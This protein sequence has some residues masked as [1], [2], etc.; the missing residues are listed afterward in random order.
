M[1]I[2]LAQGL[3]TGLL[4]IAIYLLGKRITGAASA[5]D[6]DDEQ[7]QRPKVFAIRGSQLVAAGVVAA[8]ASIGSHVLLTA[9]FRPA[10]TVFVQD[11]PF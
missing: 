4:F 1:E 6:D 9:N 2:L 3:V 5:S 10:A 7:D 11:P 8:L